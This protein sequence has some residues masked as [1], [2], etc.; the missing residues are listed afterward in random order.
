MSVGGVRQPDSGGSPPL[1]GV[2]WYADVSNFKDQP[3]GCSPGRVYYLSGAVQTVSD[4]KGGGSALRA[5]HEDIDVT[6]EVVIQDT[7][8]FE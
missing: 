3:C 8:V 4:V 6:I 7:T 1:E 5:L 2:S